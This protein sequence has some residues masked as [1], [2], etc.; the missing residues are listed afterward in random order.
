MGNRFVKRK[1]SKFRTSR[2][3]WHDIQKK[4]IKQ[5]RIIKSA[6]TARFWRW[7]VKTK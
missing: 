5:S 3:A 6:H 1:K 2:A 4:G 7:L